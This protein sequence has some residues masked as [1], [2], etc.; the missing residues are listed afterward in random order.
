[1]NEVL[2]R[3]LEQEAHLIEKRKHLP[4]GTSLLVAA[5]KV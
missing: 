5:R 1:V 4:V 2:Y 3:V